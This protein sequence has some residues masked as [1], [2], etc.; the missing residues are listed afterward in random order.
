MA[1]WRSLEGIWQIQYTQTK[2]K[3]MIVGVC[4]PRGSYK[5]FGSSA[6]AG[7][8][9][10]G[11]GTDLYVAVATQDVSTNK[12]N[13]VP[14]GSTWFQCPG[15]SLAHRG[16]CGRRVSLGWMACPYCYS[17]YY[18]DPEGLVDI[19]QARVLATLP[20]DAA[21]DD[22]NCEARHQAFHNFHQRSD[23]SK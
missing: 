17:E 6:S 9:G 23:T 18:Y 8:A 15:L 20:T 13:P 2:A 3:E 22:L 5:S 11:G 19:I 1:A 4:D 7:S 10:A 21:I 16:Q 12:E 14:E